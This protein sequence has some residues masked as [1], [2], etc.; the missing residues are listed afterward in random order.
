MSSTT[1]PRAICTSIARPSIALAELFPRRTL[2]PLAEAVA[3]G[4]A[5]VR[6]ALEDVEVL[7]FAARKVGLVALAGAVKSLA[8]RRDPP[9]YARCL[10][11][12]DR[13]AQLLER[14]CG[15]A[16]A[17]RAARPWLALRA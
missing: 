11:L 10:H 8:D 9:A 15:V 2:P 7:S 3:Q 12:A 5:G 16:A 6:G 4:E 17:A 13:L 14:E 1:P